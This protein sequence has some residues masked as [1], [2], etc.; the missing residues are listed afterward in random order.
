LAQK[1]PGT[2]GKAW[3]HSTSFKQTVSGGKNCR[4]PQRDA[5]VLV[6]KQTQ[7][8]LP[9]SQSVKA[10]ELVQKS[11]LAVQ[12]PWP[13]MHRPP[14][15]ILNAPHSASLQHC[16]AGMQAPPQGLVPGQQALAGTH[17]VPHRFSVPGQ[18]ERFGTQRFPHRRC[19]LGQHERFGIQRV[20]HRFWDLL[21]ALAVTVTS[22]LASASRPPKPPSSV[23]R[24][25]LSCFVKRSNRSLSMIRSF[26][27]ASRLPL[28]SE[29]MTGDGVL[30]N[31]QPVRAGSL[32]PQTAVALQ[33]ASLAR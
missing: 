21:H 15:Q 28:P 10:P 19:V 13:V 12:V 31:I 22:P 27:T 20:P 4:L 33:A 24:R 25:V 3:P 7:S 26:A 9:R 18:Q 6:M 5:S 32:A 1:T 17:R 11:A 30:T 8:A 16:V 2:P 29:A 23:L 14:A